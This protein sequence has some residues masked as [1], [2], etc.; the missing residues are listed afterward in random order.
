M[1][2]ALIALLLLPVSS[3]GGCAARATTAAGPLEAVTALERARFAAL[4]ANDLPAL[5]T[6]LAP[7]LRYCH[8]T[9]VCETRAEFLA[10]LRSGQMRYRR[11]EVLALEPR[12]VGDAVL[13]HGRLDLEAEMRG[14][15]VAMQLVYTDLYT[16]REG[17]WQLIAWQSTRAPTPPAP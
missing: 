13:I 17:R 8:S 1:A 11:I 15:A 14:N 4:Q 2:P 6:M 16:L 10:A 3:L 9:G 12:A 5:E 7:D